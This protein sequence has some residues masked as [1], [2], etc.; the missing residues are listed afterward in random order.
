MAARAHGAT[1]SSATRHDTTNKRTSV[2]YAARFA[3]IDLPRSR[4]Q[5]TC[6]MRVCVWYATSAERRAPCGRCPGTRARQ[7]S[8]IIINMAMIVVGDGDVAVVVAA[9]AV[10]IIEQ[11]PCALVPRRKGVHSRTEREKNA[12]WLMG[13]PHHQRLAAR[14][15]CARTRVA[16]LSC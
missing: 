1:L 2:R 4:V 7:R 11:L 3:S 5:S 9:A 14:W 13:V 16:R 6:L 12:M 15:A 8:P 10:V